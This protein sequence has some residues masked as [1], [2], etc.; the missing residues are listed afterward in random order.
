MFFELICSCTATFHMEVSE[1]QTTSAWMF[2]HRFVN[3]HQN[4]GFMTAP[5]YPEVKEVYKTEKNNVESE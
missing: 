1:D 3:A 2:A 4:C 5:A